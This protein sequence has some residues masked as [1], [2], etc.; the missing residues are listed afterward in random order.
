MEYPDNSYSARE[1]KKE[2][3]APPEKKVEKVVT[4][5]VKTRKKGGLR[6]LAGTFVPDN[7]DEIKA[8]ILSDVIGPGIRNALADAV[9][10]ALFGEP[11]LI[12]PKRDRGARIAYEKRYG[13]DRRDN[14]RSRFASGYD[15]D[16]IILDTRGEAERILDRLE[17]IIATYSIA[18]VAD[19]Y[20]LAG[21]TNR[22]YTD[23]K[24]GWTDI[25]SA[26]VVPV[27]DGYIL[28]LPKALPID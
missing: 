21:V 6:K 18:S 8:R 1:K 15:Y 23:N 26:K 2:N 27:R 13:E 24:Y 7:P 20:D 22:G 28:R 4:G 25:R 17:D 12:G 19:L 16:D 10:I 3:D 9:S 14:R 11:G 5:P